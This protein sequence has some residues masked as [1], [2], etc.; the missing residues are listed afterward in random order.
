MT[1][2]GLGFD[3]QLVAGWPRAASELRNARSPP[4]SAVCCYSA[5][6]FDGPY[7]GFVVADPGECCV[8][9]F[10]DGLGG[11]CAYDGNIRLPSVYRPASCSLSRKDVGQIR[12]TRSED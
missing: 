1:G 12:S 3:R 7:V 8:D 5:P 6:R 4:V 9:L 2:T 11:V 10:R